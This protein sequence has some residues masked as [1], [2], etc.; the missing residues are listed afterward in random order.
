MF[1]SRIGGLIAPAVILA[2]ACSPTGDQATAAPTTRAS[3]PPN[4]TAPPLATLDP[5]RSDAGVFGRVTI[6]NDTRADRNGVYDIYGV[7]DDGSECSGAFEEPDY[8]VVAYDEDAAD[9]YLRQLGVSVAAAD[10]PEED[11]IIY[12]IANGGVSFDF[13]SET[14]FGTT[15][16]GNSTRE[17]QGSSTIDVTRSGAGLVFDFTGVTY[18][19]VTFTGTLVC[20]TSG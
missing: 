15:Y 5:S 13:A 14:G 10:I 18:D 7:D 11:G 6:D 3:A 9:G 17:N 12:G 20:T 19:A 16:S 8:I 1:L 4:P 2:V